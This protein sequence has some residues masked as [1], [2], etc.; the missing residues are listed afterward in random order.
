M[1]CYTYRE[2]ALEPPRALTFYYYKGHMQN[3]LMISEQFYS[4]QMEG[5]SVGTPAVFLRLT[6]CNLTCRGF[7]AKGKEGQHIG[8]DS[9][10]VWRS[11]KNQTFD[12][13]L[14]MWEQSKWIDMFR[15]KAHLVIS[16]GE[17]LLRQEAIALFLKAFFARYSFIPFIEVETNCTIIPEAGLDTYV[18]QYNV[19]PKLST[20]GDPVEKT[21]QPDVLKFFA[22]SL[23][24]NFKFVIQNDS[25]IDEV[26]TKFL[27][28]FEINPTRV[29]FMPE[30]ATIDTIREHSLWLV[31]KCKNLT[32]RFSPRLHISIWDRMTGV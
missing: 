1:R 12:E 13:V 26:L 10:E 16:G 2:D 11:G 5:I 32:I 21:F 14:D 8:C 20:N 29:C 6:S 7:T 22:K 19:S 9:A 4:C 28:P 15:R 24:A 25:D 27:A 23:T 18:S 30:G 31:E 3:T 17:P